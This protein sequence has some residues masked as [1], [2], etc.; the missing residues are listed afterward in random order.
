MN[1]IDEL[2]KEIKSLK[3][4]VIK[5]EE[6]GVAKLYYSLSRKAWEMADMLNS[7][8]MKSLALDDPKDKTFERMRFIINDSA[9]IASAVKALGDAAG[10]T[11]NE[12]KD[13]A[14]KPFVDTIA[15]SRK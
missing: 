1:E 3:A 2:E 8:N 15:D 5:Y 12:E 13:V 10:V 9:G 7:I 4:L 6:N 11:G 14:R